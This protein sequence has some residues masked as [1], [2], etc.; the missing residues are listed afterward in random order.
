MNKLKNNGEHMSTFHVKVRKIKIVPH[1]DAERLEIAVVDDY[2]SCVRKGDFADG[3][4]AVYIPESAV[5]P[6][7]ILRACGLWDEVN[8]KGMCAGELGNRVH[9][10]RLRGV[11]SQGVLMPITD[12]LNIEFSLT[13]FNFEEARSLQ[14]GDEIAHMLGIVKYKPELPPFME[15]DIIE[16]FDYTRH[17][18]I[19]SAQ[20]F[21]NAL[22]EGEEVVMTEKLHGV[23]CEVGV[24]AGLNDERLLNGNM[25]ATSKGFANDGI[26]FENTERNATDNIYQKTLLKL[27]KEFKEVAR[28]VRQEY[29]SEC[30]E[31]AHVFILGEI[32]G[33]GSGQDLHYGMKDVAFRVFDIYEGPPTAGRFLDYDEMVVACTGTCLN[34]VPLLYRGPYSKEVILEN[35]DGKTMFAGANVREGG[36]VK[37]TKERR[38]LELGR[39]ILKFVS[40]D[41]HTRKAKKGQKVTEY[42]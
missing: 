32:F 12:V 22:I 13:F 16:L 4:L 20:A 18:D 19:E 25:F 6:E 9:A 1:P 35:R 14:E 30:E 10:V 33:M 38:D 15:G 17:F 3:D 2:Q 42:S 36:V 39:V 21:P 40:P 31:T 24:I 29:D 37:P 41:Y 23:F 34:T 8:R 27:E 5:L 28:R 11:L 26:V 7:E